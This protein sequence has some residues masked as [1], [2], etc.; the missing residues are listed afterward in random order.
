[1]TDRVI[2]ANA[3]KLDKVPA[4][5]TLIYVGRKTTYKPEYGLDFSILGNPFTTR[6]HTREEAVA[7]YRQWLLSRQNYGTPQGRVLHQLLERI[8][9]GEKLALV[10]WCAPISPCHAEVVKAILLEA[11]T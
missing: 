5:F 11:V 3:R 2:V 10:C 4:G 9:Q 1:M 8:E 7:L 6:Q